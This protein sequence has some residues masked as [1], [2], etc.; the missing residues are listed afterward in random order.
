MV[1][2]TS[3][4]KPATVPTIKRPPLLSMS[5]QA[6]EPA[7]TTA[8]YWLADWTYLPCQL[9]A[10][11]NSEI[12]GYFTVKTTRPIYDTRTGRHQLIPQGQRIGA[13]AETA[14]LL[15]GNERIP[16]F[17]LSFSLPDGRRVDL[18]QA[19]IMD[20]TGTNGLTGIVDKHVWRLVWTSV[21]IGGL[22][23][24]QQVLQQQ[25]GQ[26]GAGPVASGI[27]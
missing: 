3:P 5:R 9:E 15:F 1:T 17:G 20:A 21:F 27:T 8:T 12:P 14:D 25:L 7:P 6:P 18:G 23:G 11:L 4:P 24:G 26:D 2:P 16:T 10:V 22:R 13:K 19:P